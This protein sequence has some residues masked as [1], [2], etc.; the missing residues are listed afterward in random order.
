[1]AS[2][3]VLQG[4]NYL[5]PLIVVPY[6]VRVLGPEKFG[7]VAFAQAFSVYFVLIADYGFNLSATRE[8]SIYRT[9]PDKIAE[10]VS[11]VMTIK[12]VLMVL[13]AVATSAIVASVPR[14]RH[15]WTLYAASYLA[16]AGSVA[17][18]LWLFQGLERMRFVTIF[19]I[20][21]RLVSI[22]AIFLWVKQESDYIYA[23]GFQAGGTLLAGVMSW[24]VMHLLVP[25]RL[26][27]P[28]YATVGK[29]LRE[30]WH[31]F[32][33]TAA[34]SLYTASNTLI[35]GL[36]AGNVAV[37]YFSAAEKL[38]RAVQG[39]VRP[40]SQAIYPH[41]SNLVSQSR[42]VALAFVRTTLRWIGGAGFLASCLLFLL[43]EPLV[44]IVLGG[45]YLDSVPLVQWMAFLPF[46]I[47]VSNVFGIQTML[48]FG[49][50]KDFS[51]IL[52]SAGIFNLVLI[53]PLSY[54]F[55]AKGAA[56]AVLLTELVV[57]VAMCITLP[58]R[59]LR[60]LGRTSF[61]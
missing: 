5:L 21:G 6:L 45:Q 9:D 55:H 54:F 7:A 27:R 60:V 20:A 37:G 23:A 25:V 31:V 61:A 59:G 49:L 19:N 44:G 17:F 16:V 32:I 11:T 18:P 46:L 10:I 35:L 1:M 34:I 56:I 57:T 28:T 41:I 22:A 50:Q 36:L 53:I 3:F 42:E 51:K 52:I 14:F 33:S 15:D 2:L 47:A 12:C 40:V 13:G 24:G 8:I 58:R 38:I 4:A 43:A 26:P 39:L 29:H 48:P 30:G